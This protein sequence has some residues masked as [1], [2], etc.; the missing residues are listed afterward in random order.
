MKEKEFN[1]DPIVI[2]DKR[3]RECPIAWEWL[4]A[5]CKWEGVN[6]YTIIREYYSTVENLIENGDT[7]NLLGYK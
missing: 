1:K 4:I 5:K 2:L 6:R 3:A 7:E